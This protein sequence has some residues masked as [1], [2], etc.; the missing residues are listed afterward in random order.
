MRKW[1]SPFFTFKGDVMNDDDV[2]ISKIVKGIVKAITHK[3]ETANFNKGLTGRVISN[4]GD[5][6]YSVMI[7]G[8]IYT[9]K[10]RFTL[11]EGQVVKLIKWNNRY[12]ELYVIY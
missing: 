12:D 10:S 6:K 5:N 3:I 4:L 2:A 11:D 9:A 8:N 1:L 7:N